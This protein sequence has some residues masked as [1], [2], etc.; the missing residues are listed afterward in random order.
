MNDL[1]RDVQIHKELI[2]D[3]ES[4]RSDLQNH[5]TQTSVNLHQDTEEHKK[6]ELSLVSETESLRAEIQAM[7]QAQARREQEILHQ[8]EDLHTSHASKVKALTNDHN[9]KFTT[10]S[11][12]SQQRIDRLQRENHEKLTQVNINAE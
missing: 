9:Q 4:K 8:L 11:N 3:S 7:K 1:K 2:R 10:L 12:E 5:I 6:Y